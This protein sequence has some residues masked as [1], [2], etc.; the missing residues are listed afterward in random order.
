M[1]FMPP[2]HFSIFTVQRGTIMPFML[3][4]A[5]DIIGKLAFDP[6]WG[7]FEAL[8]MVRFFTDSVFTCA[9]ALVPAS[10]VCPFT[11]A[12]VGSTNSQVT[13]GEGIGS[14]NGR[15]GPWPLVVRRWRRP[16]PKRRH[17]FS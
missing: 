10:G 1:I 13:V 5:P 8:G 17:I 16:N 3:G 4:A 14:M 7:H 11:A 9:P 2:V 15:T 12:D 6:G